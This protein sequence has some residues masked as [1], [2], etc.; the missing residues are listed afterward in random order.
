MASAKLYLSKPHHVHY[1]YD[2]NKMY[3]CIIYIIK[4][5]IE[6]VICFNEKLCIIIIYTQINCSPYFYIYTNDGIR[7]IL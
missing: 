3:V 5:V 7:D 4:Y 2:G 1:I 6:I